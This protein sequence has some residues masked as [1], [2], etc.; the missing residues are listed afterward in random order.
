M[1]APYTPTTRLKS[2]ATSS[3]PVS[4]S[5]RT[6]VALLTVITSWGI[7]QT[8]CHPFPAK[9]SSTALPTW[10][11]CP[12]MATFRSSHLSSEQTDHPTSVSR[13]P[14]GSSSTVSTKTCLT[15]KWA[16]TKNSCS[17]LCS[18]PTSQ[19]TSRCT[20]EACSKLT[21]SNKIWCSKVSPL[22]SR[23][24]ISRPPASI[25]ILPNTTNQLLLRIACPCQ[26]SASSLRMSR[27]WLKLKLRQSTPSERPYLMACNKRMSEK[28]GRHS[29]LWKRV[30]SLTQKLISILIC[31]QECREQ[32][33]RL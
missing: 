15:I 20:V 13:T 29:G 7:W 19:T 3:K 23:S 24:K 8:H 6:T 21:P 5:S 16:R 4:A 33:H 32:R 28:G 26:L 9:S 25:R 30:K 2:V 27:P 18:R 22:A 12:T 10:N 1:S 31:E 17:N 11:S 14:L